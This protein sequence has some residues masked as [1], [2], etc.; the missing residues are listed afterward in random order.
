MR[1]V[2]DQEEIDQ[3]KAERALI[4]T[5]IDHAY[6]LEKVKWLLDACPAFDAHVK[7]AWHLILPFKGR[8]FAVD[9]SMNPED[10]DI[11]KARAEIDRLKVAH[12]ELPCIVFDAVNDH[13]Y[14]L[15]L[16]GMK[17]DEVIKVIGEIGDIAVKC[18]NDDQLDRS[19]FKNEVN[20]KVMRYLRR[21]RL[22]S[23][24]K[25]S[26]PIVGPLLGGVVDIKELAKELV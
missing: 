24:A 3:L 16:G 19:I 17:K 22:L 18:W 2:K 11:E 5:Y 4:G 13:K 23:V 14:F 20:R 7:D 8:G 26:L 10:Y 6:D 15:K 9:V 1:G 12:G 21:R 25:K